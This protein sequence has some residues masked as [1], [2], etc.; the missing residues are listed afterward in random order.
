MHLTKLLMIAALAATPAARAGE[1]DWQE[2]L[3]GVTARVISAD[4]VD[5]GGR[6]LVGLEL[7][8]P[9]GHKT[10]WR[11]PGETGLPPQFDLSGS[12]GI[13]GHQPVWP[14]PQVDETAGYLDFVYTGRVV[15]PIEVSLEDSESG[16]LALDMF[17]GICSDICVPAQARFDLTLA[18]E[19]DR[20]NGLR[21]RQAVATAP[22]AGSG[23]V[24]AARVE[25]GELVLT[26]EPGAARPDSLIVACADGEAVFGAARHV[27]RTGEVRIP[28]M[29]RPNVS[30]THRL[31]ILYATPQGPLFE[32][33]EVRLD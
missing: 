24:E 16:D 13:A 28:L 26:L 20:A 14:M 22:L 31:E 7:D 10:Y 23:L 19:P 12:R 6:M 21:L 33:V 9:P 2:L 18:D 11:V 17:V 29:G 1:S 3:P 32:Q 30:G 8:L 4:A 5:A 25:A 27:P 15:L